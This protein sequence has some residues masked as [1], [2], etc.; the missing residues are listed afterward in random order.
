M[1]LDEAIFSHGKFK[2][3]RPLIFI[4]EGRNID[5]SVADIVGD[6]GIRCICPLDRYVSLRSISV[7]HYFVSFYDTRESGQKQILLLQSQHIINVLFFRIFHSIQQY[8]HSLIFGTIF[9]F[10]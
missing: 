3:H 5:I 10:D 1:L 2:N 9:Y 6:F 4:G 8:H 7:T